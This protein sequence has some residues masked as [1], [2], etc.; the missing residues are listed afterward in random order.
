MWPLTQVL[1]INM[2]SNLVGLFY[3]AD[4]SSDSLISM[5]VNIKEKNT[6]AESFEFTTDAMRVAHAVAQDRF[7]NSFLF[8]AAS[9]AYQI[10][11][12]YNSSGINRFIGFAYRRG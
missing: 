8:G 12:A 10:E 9:S 1:S 6:I 7:P 11:G 2:L 3:V 4:Y 5:N